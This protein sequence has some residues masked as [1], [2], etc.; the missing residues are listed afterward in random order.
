M[1]AM[2]KGWRPEWRAAL[3]AAGLVSVVGL[4]GFTNVGVKPLASGSKVSIEIF[5]GKD[6]TD[7]QAQITLLTKLIKGFEKQNPNIT[8]TWS[9]YD[10]ASQETSVLETSVAT[11]TGPSVFEFGSTIVPTAYATGAFTVLTPKDWAALGGK[12]KFFQTQL[13]MSG[14]SPSQYIAVPEYVLPFALLYNKTMFQKAGIKAPPTTW[15]QFVQDA[16]KLT[17]PSKNVWGVAMDP[18]DP[19]DPWHIGWVLTRQR[20]GNF[21]NPSGTKALLDSPPSVAALTFWFDWMTKFHIASINDVTYKGADELQAFENG[22]A[23][24]LVMQG[25]TL[26]PSLN[27]SPVA[28]DYAFAPMPT[29]PYGMSH[30][31]PGGVPVQTFIS[32]QYYCIP[33][34]LT[35]AEFQAALK[36]IKYV[37]SVP[38]QRM[39]FTYYGYMPANINA[40]KNYA[41]LDTPEMKAFFTAEEHA[42]PT[43]FIGAWG[44]LEVAYGAASAKIADEIGTHTFK[45]GDIRA[46]LVAANQAVQAQLK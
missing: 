40:Y 34:Y 24:M 3:A 27:Q 35:P 16:Q 17:D 22:Q 41:P 25:P 15:T 1:S 6:T 32:G 44:T 26:I 39:F 28:H 18:S 30:M 4:T 21:V 42:Y 19:Y 14:P 2:E 12:A 8:V 7:P 13:G 38:Q 43:P 20:G 46:A 10:S 31:P 45:P 11:H 33:K 37:T 29:V 23:A 5:V 9:T 36:W